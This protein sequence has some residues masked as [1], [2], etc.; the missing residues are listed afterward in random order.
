MADLV[1]RRARGWLVAAVL[2]AVLA[3]SVL[4]AGGAEARTTKVPPGPGRV[5]IL[6]LPW[7]EEAGGD[8]AL[9]ARL[10]ERRHGLAIGL[11]SPTVGG[12]T[13]GAFALDLSQGTR[14]PLGLLEGP[15]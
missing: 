12:Y 7:P 5:A 10:G 6:L 3:A 4:G 14:V 1:V 11:T 2:A 15:E 8:R 13:P 9:L